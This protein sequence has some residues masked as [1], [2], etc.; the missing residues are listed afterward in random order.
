MILLSVHLK[1]AASAWGPTAYEENA[2]SSLCEKSAK[3]EG[4]PRTQTDTNNTFS[5]RK[6]GKGI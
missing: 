1:Q 4:H 2:V 5:K 3:N 6:W